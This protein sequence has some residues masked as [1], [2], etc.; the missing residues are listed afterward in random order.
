MEKYSGIGRKDLDKTSGKS[1]DKEPFVPE[2]TIEAS[3]TEIDL[4][5][6]FTQ[7]YDFGTLMTSLRALELEID[8][9]EKGKSKKL[10]LKYVPGIQKAR[11]QEIVDEH[12][13][14]PGELKWEKIE[15]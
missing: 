15:G 9:E 8:T 11:V 1:K 12:F 4:K 7:G 3:S 13:V 5:D 14:K 10:I 2:R 6:P